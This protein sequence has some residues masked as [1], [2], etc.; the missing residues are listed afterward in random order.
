[1]YRIDNDTAISTLPTPE[2]E[3]VNPDYYFT[4]GN[5]S[6][7]VP[8]TV[9]DADWAN[10]VQEEICGVI[11]GAGL[12]LDKTSQSQLLA[13]I[14]LIISGGGGDYVASTSSANT[15]T[16]TLT[17]APSAYAAGQ[18]IT[19]KFT[20]HNTGAATINFNSLGAKSIKRQ[21]GSALN[22]Y[23]I[24]DSMVAILIYDGTNFILANGFLGYSLQNESHNY[25]ASTTAANTYTTTLDPVPLAYTTGMRIS[26]K[27][28]NANTGAAT[29]NCNSLGAKSITLQDGTAL[30]GGEMA[31]G[32]IA[33]LR[34]DGTNFQLMNAMNSNVTTTAVLNDGY[35][36]A[37]STTA[38]NTYTATITPA[39]TA[40]TTGMS[41]SIK[42][43]NHNTGA[44]TINLNSLGAKSIVRQS[45]A[46]LVGGEIADGMMARLVYDG[47]NFQLQNPAPIADQVTVYTSGSGTYN[48]PA[49]AIAIEVEIVGGG[50]GGHGNSNNGSIINNPTAGGNTTFGS[51]TANGGAYGV[52][53]NYV[54]G[55][56]GTCSGGDLNV[57]GGDGGG[58]SQNNSTASVNQL[59]GGHGGASFFGS[60]GGGGLNASGFTAKPYGAG[61]GGGGTTS[62]ASYCTGSGGGAGGY[63]RKL[64]SS[65]SSSYSYAVGSGGAGGNGSNYNGNSGKD[66]VVIIRA[67]FQ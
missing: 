4:K 11:E 25:A 10:A 35:K 50:S 33:D 40:Y 66:G 28:T 45:G 42:F 32:G 13:A 38:A 63:C 58:G 47:T 23:D 24:V 62:N 41:V 27:F 5:P 2:A 36:Y 18:F 46:A 49:G 51:L 3:G 7:G 44:A 12:T 61:G 39:P 31:A 8:A 37:A 1:M 14:K 57:T 55:L 59:A 26:I 53:N 65:P 34:Y 21:D 15:Y 20:N 48:V 43:T 67:I 29:I 22:A 54:P 52:T 16:A 60:G 6:L 9:V 19:V 56:G 30:A 17:P 64:I